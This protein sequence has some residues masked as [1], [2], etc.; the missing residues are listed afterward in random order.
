MYVCMY[1]IYIYIYIYIYIMHTRTGP[2]SATRN[3]HECVHFPTEGGILVP[4]NLVS[5]GTQF[6]I[7]ICLHTTTYIL[8]KT[9]N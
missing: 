2:A 5:Y 4:T 9:L 8:L 1:V 3:A 7:L 6:Y